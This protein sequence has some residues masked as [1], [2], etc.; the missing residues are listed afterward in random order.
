MENPLSGPDAY[1][2]FLSRIP[3]EYPDVL[4][5]TVRYIPRGTWFGRANGLILFRNDLVLC[6]QEFLNFELQV[7]EGYG[8]EVSRSKLDADELPES[9]EYCRASFPNKE[10]RWWYDSFPHPND[11]SL[12][13]THP[14]HKHVPPDI[15][16]NRIP[17]P[18]LTFTMPNLPFLIREVISQSLQP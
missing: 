10:K 6:V 1:S 13:S 16:H 2:L 4:R 11:R 12:A 18:E 17:A 7:I 15:K 5:S 3:A 9:E 14:H 8:Y